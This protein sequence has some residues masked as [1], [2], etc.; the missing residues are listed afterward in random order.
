MVIMDKERS[1]FPL[2]I[3]IVNCDRRHESIQ[4]I[5]YILYKKD[6]GI[7]LKKNTIM[8]DLGDQINVLDEYITLH[9]LHVSLYNIYVTC[10]LAILVNLLGQ[11]YVS[12]HC[13]IRY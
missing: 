2:N 1:S 5:G 9:K 10:D 4:L 8:R 13:C 11:E 6:S 12:S 7:I 3:Y